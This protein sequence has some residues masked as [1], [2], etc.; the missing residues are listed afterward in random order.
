M[1]WWTLQ[2]KLIVGKEAISYQLFHIRKNLCLDDANQRK[3]I[4]GKEAIFISR[5][6]ALMN[7]NQRKLIVGK[8]AIFIS[9]I[10][11]T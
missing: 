5:T 2:R 1:P 7:A 11:H 8:E 4:V 3:L 6:Y 10:S 9:I